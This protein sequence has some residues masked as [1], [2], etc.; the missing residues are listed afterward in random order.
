MPPCAVYAGCCELVI[1]SLKIADFLNLDIEEVL[2]SQV[3]TMS[4]D[5]EIARKSG[6]IDM[7]EQLRK[8]DDEADAKIA[9]A[10]TDKERTEIEKGRKAAKRDVEAIRDRLRGQY[11]LPTDPDGIVLRAGRIARNLNYMR[12]LGGVILKQGMTSTYRDGFI[13]LVTNYRTF[14]MAAEEVKQAGTA[15]DM[16]LDSRAM[17]L[18]DITGEFGRHSAFERGLSAVSSKFGVV[19]LMAPWNAA[20]KRFSGMVVM[21]NIL[22]SAERVARGAGTA[23]D[24]RK[25][26]AGNIYADMAS[27]IVAEFKRHGDTQGGIMLAKA[28]AWADNDAREAFRVAVV[29]DVDRIIVTPGQDK[30][31]WMSTELGKTVGQFKTFGVASMQRISYRVCSNETPPP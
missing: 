31:L 29:R 6:S 4:A 23:D 19:T 30:P 24:I 14:R 20:M 17:A 8:I 2:R 9:V 5:V 25:L 7:A 18:A 3:R 11:A 1:E 15:L 13:P 21:T 16:I 27:R 10:K 12:L 26:A 22:R 28:A